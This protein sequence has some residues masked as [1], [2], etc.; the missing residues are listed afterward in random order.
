MQPVKEKAAPEGLWLSQ[1]DGEFSMKSYTSHHKL[2]VVYIGNLPLGTSQQEIHTLFAQYGEVHSVMVLTDKARETLDHF[3]WV[4]MGQA[5]A[6]I[7][8]L[9]EA[10]LNGQ[11]LCVQRMGVLYPNEKAL[12]PDTLADVPD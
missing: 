8:A 5:D 3:G 11:R 2:E 9:D 4:F 10:D 1:N 6:A 7:K 12:L